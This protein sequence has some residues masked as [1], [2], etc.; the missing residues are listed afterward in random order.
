MISSEEEALFIQER[1]QTATWLNLAKTSSSQ[2]YWQSGEPLNF[3]KWFPGQPSELPDHSC[4]VVDNRGINSGWKAEHC[5]A[6]RTTVCE[7]GNFT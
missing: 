3:T 4:A 5:S 6:C 2:W 7:K 1:I